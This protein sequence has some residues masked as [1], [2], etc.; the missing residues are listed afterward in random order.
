MSHRYLTWC[1]I[2]FVALAALL[3][4][5][6][7]A[8]AERPNVLFISIDD[9][10]PTLGCYDDS[11]AKT[12]EMDRLA[13]RGTTF[14]NNHCQQAM[15]AASRAS[16][17]T[18]L[19]PDRTG[20]WNFGE[21]MRQKTP[22]VV[23]LPQYFKQNGYESRGKGK[24]FDPR[25]V[26][27]EF[28]PV[29]WSIPFERPGETDGDPEAKVTTKIMNISLDRTQDGKTTTRV[30]EWMKEMAAGE[31]PFFLAVGLKKPH[32]PFE[33]P[34]EFWDLY[35][36]NSISVAP[37]QKNA[38]NGPEIAYHNSG[39]M[40]AYED[41]GKKQRRRMELPEAKQ[42]DL[43]RGYYACTSMADALVGQLVRAVADLGLTE[44]TIVVV[45]GDHGW[46]LGDHELWCKH[47]NFEQ[48]TRSPLIIVDPG[49]KDPVARTA[50]PTEFVDLF[51]TLCDLAGLEIPAGL[52]GVSLKPLMTG[53]KESVKDVA[54][55]QWPK[56]FGGK[57][58]IGYS[59]RSDRYRYTM[60][61]PRE[62]ADSPPGPVQFEE[63]YDYAKDPLETVSHLTTPEYQDE[64][65]RLRRRSAEV[66]KLPAG[67]GEASSQA[68]P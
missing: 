27:P 42:K 23:T 54:R 21:M 59:V 24:I 50:T 33:A 61:L 36:E 10:K 43:I 60:W 20:I 65:A 45:W 38:K 62:S 29:S 41:I 40:S 53:E 12:P 9:L 22:D 25:N 56:P 58:M 11:F 55:S 57:K 18:G 34:K 46:H 44:K 17:L 66:F 68:A 48:A 28:D 47:S 15:C 30:I 32:L 26:D 3:F 64:V 13:M 7:S 37:F 8:F 31:K 52:D 4:C 5:S 51:P 16:L 67:L 14:L 2:L 49:L 63:F 19:V 1:L 39:E 35:P 6:P